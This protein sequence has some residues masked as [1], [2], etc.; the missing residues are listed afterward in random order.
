MFAVGYADHAW[1]RL[2]TEKRFSLTK[3]IQI[4]IVAGTAACIGNIVL[5]KA[6]KFDDLEIKAG[7]ST[8][9]EA[10]SSYQ[11]K[12]AKEICANNG[13]TQTNPGACLIAVGR[14]Y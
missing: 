2:M 8:L 10:R 6:A 5:G 13:V 7:M 3:I 4:V 1:V 9:S 11:I 14:K 12:S